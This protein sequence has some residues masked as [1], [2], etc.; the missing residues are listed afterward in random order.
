MFFPWNGCIMSKVMIMADISESPHRILTFS[1]LSSSGLMVKAYVSA[2]TGN[3]KYGTSGSWWSLWPQTFYCLI[4]IK[5]CVSRIT[6]LKDCQKDIC[7][8]EGIQSFHF[9]KAHEISFLKLLVTGKD[10]PLSW[11]TGLLWSQK[12]YKTFCFGQFVVL[13]WYP[14]LP[15]F[16]IIPISSFLSY[17]IEC[18]FCILPQI[19][20]GV[21]QVLINYRLEKGLMLIGSKGKIRIYD[22]K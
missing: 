20:W 15:F 21:M 1:I 8:K 14:I 4:H 2:I 10:A 18:I 9:R 17:V 6:C 5:H 19:L 16:N 7:F 3:I 12:H 22:S 11:S 13:F